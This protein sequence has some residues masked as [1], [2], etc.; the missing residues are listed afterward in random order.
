M[1]IQ[2]A[3]EL[4]RKYLD[5]I[6]NLRTLRYGNNE[7][8]LWKSKVNVILEA[9]FGKDSDEYMWLNPTSGFVG[10]IGMTDADEQREYSR[11]LDNYELEIIKILQK[12]EILG[13][14]APSEV[15]TLGESER[16]TKAELEQFRDGLINYR[17]FIVAKKR[18]GPSWR[19][20]G[21]LRKLQ[22]DLQQKRGSIESVIEECGGSLSGYRYEFGERVKYDIL[23]SALGSTSF[24]PYPAEFIINALDAAINEVNKAIGRLEKETRLEQRPKEAVFQNGK[25]YDAYKAIIDIFSV[26]TKKLIIV[27]PYVDNTL[28]TMF[29]NVQHKVQIE[30]LTQK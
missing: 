13:I 5:E 7:R 29:E 28:F 24:K 17:E 15:A 27:D 20:E 3:L 23:D 22:L 10:W 11:A 4:L 18:A 16:N 8:W 14:P 21:E 25:T 12:Y 30:I 1:E 9:A 19:S 2:E 6:A 26:A